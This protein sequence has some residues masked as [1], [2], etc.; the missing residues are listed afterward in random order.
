MRIEGLDLTRAS[1]TVTIHREPSDPRYRTEHTLLYHVRNV[2]RAQ[3]HDV[4]KRRMSADGHLMGDD[5]LP[6]LRE[7]RGR[8]AI[9]DQ[10]WQIRAMHEAFNAG[11]VR[12]TFQQWEK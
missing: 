7:R 4:I 11:A 10:S 1:G 8:W 3:G 12:L 6:Y 9:Y 2:L 5:T